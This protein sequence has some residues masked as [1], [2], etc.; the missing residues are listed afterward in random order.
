MVLAAYT[1]ANA[2]LRLYEMAEKLGDRLYYVDTD[3]AIFMHREGMYS[4][5]LGDFLGGLK[6]EVPDDVISEYVGL[7]PKNYGLKLACGEAV[8]K[9]R[10][11]SL[12]YRA[13]KLINFDTLKSMVSGGDGCTVREPHAILRKGLGALYTGVREKHYRMVYDKR[14]ISD[15][16]VSTLPL[17]FMTSQQSI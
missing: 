14:L 10:G 12:N 3:S 17:G 1:T 6:D 9:V 8:C 11:F 16:G 7:G 2:R 15:D 4:P 13:S 5:P